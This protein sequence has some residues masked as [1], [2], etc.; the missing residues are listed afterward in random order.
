MSHLLV[1]LS[2]AGLRPL[3]AEMCKAFGD[4]LW[5]DDL[6]DLVARA[7]VEEALAVVVD[8]LDRNGDSTAPA[9]AAMK[10]RRPSLPVVLWCNRLTISGEELAEF[11]RVG[12]SAIIFRD[13]SDFE[14]RIL[15]ALTRASDLA[16][17]E[18]TD[19]A[20]HRRVPAGLIPIFR[21]CLDRAASPLTAESVGRTVGLSAKALGG[22]L[23]RA[24]MP[25]VATIVSWSQALAAA[26][27]LEHSAEPATVIARSLGFPNTRSL[28][29]VLKRC[30]NE[31]P[32]N[33]REQGGF[34]WVLRCFERFL[35]KAQRGKA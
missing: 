15:S 19:Q 1:Q 11:A 27:R 33:L 31:T 10:A 17:H 14:Q 8:A 16:F 13:E 20:L 28:T 18:M 22:E 25:P 32:T 5:C 23:K 35:V 6:N 7:A 9:V 2:E 34:G 26:Y 29:S 21:Y 4:M 30:C 3:F 24:G 12:I